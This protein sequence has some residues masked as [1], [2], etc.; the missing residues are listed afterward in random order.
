MK[1]LS[2]AL[3]AMQ[4]NMRKETMNENIED[5][6][7]ILDDLIKLSFKQEGLMKSFRTLKSMNPM[8]V[9]LSQEQLKLKDQVTVLS[10]SLLALSKRVVAIS[11]FVTSELSELNRNINASILSLRQRK[12]N[13]AVVNQQFSMTS[14]NNLALLLNDLLQQMRDQANNQ[15]S[16]EPQDQPSGDL[17][18]LRELQQQLSE[19][20][21]QL[22]KGGLKG[23][24]LSQELAEMAARQEMI[25]NELNKLNNKLKG[26]LG[27][28]NTNNT[29]N[30]AAEDMEKN[31]LNLINKQ[32]TQELIDRQE[33]ILTRML[34]AEN[35]LINQDEDQR[36][37]AETA[38]DYKSRLPAAL[39]NY[40]KQKS[41]ELELLKSIPI[42][43][44][45]F[46]KSEVNEYFKRI[47]GNEKN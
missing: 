27:N 16:G 10:D 37:E 29:L 8:F 7:K 44:H 33:Q 25:R 5:L 19:Q 38:Q 43:L 21:Q 3:A 30:K 41:K 6:N 11:S 9:T 47:N 26:Q 35:A 39:D 36:R 18:N 2:D 28:E 20:I 31:E 1:N 42:N 17:P 14:M 22:K 23:R 12:A 40:L 46:Y 15:G 24:E 32:I 45:P 13:T 34:E 4:S